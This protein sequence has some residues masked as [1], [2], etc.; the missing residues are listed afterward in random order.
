MK[1]LNLY[2]VFGTDPNKGALEHYPIFTGSNGAQYV[3]LKNGYIL[4]SDA[5]K[6]RKDFIR[7]ESADLGN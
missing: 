7:T 1:C 2:A 5:K 3:H 4:L 6:L